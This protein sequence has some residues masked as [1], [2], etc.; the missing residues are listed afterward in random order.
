MLDYYTREVPCLDGVDLDDIDID[1]VAAL[2]SGGGGKQD[3]QPTK[4]SY[5]DAAK[6][7]WVTVSHRSNL[8]R[9]KKPRTVP[10]RTSCNTSKY[11]PGTTKN[12]RVG[13][14]KRYRKKSK[15]RKSTSSRWRH[16]L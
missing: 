13:A 5:A 14:R 2:A 12:S 4:T 11:K 1:E 16:S 15:S 6:S 3:I 9:E 7:E 10:T 8:T